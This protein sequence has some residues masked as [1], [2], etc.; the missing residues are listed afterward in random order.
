MVSGGPAARVAVAS[1]DSHAW[2]QWR[3]SGPRDGERAG[4][5]VVDATATAICYELGEDV[6]VPVGQA[7]AVA[8][9]FEG[10]HAAVVAGQ[11]G[12]IGIVKV[13]SEAVAQI[14]GRTE[15]GEGIL[16]SQKLHGKL[17]GKASGTEQL[18]KLDLFELASKPGLGGTEKQE[19]LQ[20]GGLGQF[21]VLAIG[22]N[23]GFCERDLMSAPEEESEGK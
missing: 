10:Y 12:E 3:A 18:E 8:D 1:G 13:W 6:E 17:F 4:E 11:R 19:T 7:V 22:I 23:Q 16:S 5:G 9:R 20:R 15:T 21:V 14:P 2:V